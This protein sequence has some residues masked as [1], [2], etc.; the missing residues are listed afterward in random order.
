MGCFAKI[1]P[2]RTSAKDSKT[3][4]CTIVKVMAF[5]VFGCSGC[6]KARKK[7]PKDIRKRFAA[8]WK[9]EIELGTKVPLTPVES[10]ETQPRLVKNQNAC[11]RLDSSIWNENT[12]K[13]L[14]R[15][16]HPPKVIDAASKREF[17]DN[18]DPAEKTIRKNSML[19]SPDSNAHSLTLN[20][21]TPE[22]RE[23][24]FLAPESVSHMR[25][26]RQQGHTWF[27]KEDDT[28]SRE[29]VSRNHTARAAREEAG[30]REKESNG[31]EKW[32]IRERVV[33]DGDYFRGTNIWEAF[34][35]EK[36]EPSRQDLALMEAAAENILEDNVMRSV[37]EK[38]DAI[39]PA[40]IE[41]ARRANTSPQ[42]PPLPVWPMTSGS[43]DTLETIGLSP[44]STSRFRRD[45]GDTTETS[46]TD[47]TIPDDSPWLKEAMESPLPATPMAQSPILGPSVAN[48]T[49]EDYFPIL[50]LPI[51]DLPG[52]KAIISDANIPDCSVPESPVTDLSAETKTLMELLRNSKNAYK[53]HLAWE[54][55]RALRRSA[56]LASEEQ[57]VVLKEFGEQG[58]MYLPS[59]PIG[60]KRSASVFRDW[61]PWSQPEKKLEVQQA[62]L[63]LATSY[64]ADV[65]TVAEEREKV[66]FKLSNKLTGRKGKGKGQA[67]EVDGWE[68][69][70]MVG[71]MCFRGDRPWEDEAKEPLS[72][73]DRARA[74]SASFI[75]MERFVEELSTADG[76]VGAS[77]GRGTEEYKRR[78]EGLD[79]WEP[80]EWEN[81][82]KA[83]DAVI[84]EALKNVKGTK[85]Y[86]RAREYE[87]IMKAEKERKERESKW[88]W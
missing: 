55:W 79:G 60:S 6:R 76:G 12:Q 81:K 35:M 38:R 65:E 16:S 54:Q 68:V 70:P 40:N 53:P 62:D 58:P 34:C 44:D 36:L 47:L 26:I 39:E 67:K 69:S 64:E 22:Q 23:W 48:M 72:Q 14:S 8:A 50:A 3:G 1:K 51:S 10:R 80:Q 15:T 41:S 52:S 33:L 84:A 63:T 61:R 28:G 45:S 7:V 88:T 18:A 85:E 31:R 49:L 2:L 59:P 75:S 57:Q 87:R 77:C 21:S 29:Q 42:P 86:Q 46:A 56:L 71:F 4:C 9:H 17:K 20:N 43:S 5:Y 13:Y 83:L 11:E 27:T 74:S 25:A 32:N 30:R 24:M 37:S 19:D 82:K 78:K 73:L 66:I